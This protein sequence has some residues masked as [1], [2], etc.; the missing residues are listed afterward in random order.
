MELCERSVWKLG[1]WVYQ[2]WREQEGIE[3]VGAREQAAAAADGDE[4]KGGKEAL[5]EE[6]M[7]KS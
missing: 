3:L 7:V 1:A 5:W 2:E 4:E 6:K